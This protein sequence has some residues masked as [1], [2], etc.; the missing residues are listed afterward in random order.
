MAIT[1]AEL[2][3]YITGG[4]VGAGNTN[5]NNSLGGPITTTEITNASINNLWDDVSGDESSTGDIE[6][7]TFAVKNTNATLTW[8]NVKAWIQ[9][10]T[11]GGDDVSI[12]LADE[13]VNASAE[14]IA[15]ENTAPSGPTFTAPSSKGAGLSL[16]N[17]PAGQYYIIWVKRNVPAS[18]TAKDANNYVI[19]VEGETGE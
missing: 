13:G 2:K 11:P 6:Y 12:A 18:T 10:Q 14:T 15:N 9:T 19:R 3:Q 16:G 1:Q 5:V 7:R 17:I 4:T 8:F